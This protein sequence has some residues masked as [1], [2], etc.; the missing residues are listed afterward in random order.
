[1]HHAPDTSKENRHMRRLI[2]GI[3]CVAAAGAA[4]TGC[5]SAK[6]DAA[7]PGATEVVVTLTNDGCAPTPASVPAGP[8]TFKVTNTNGDAV[9]EAELKSGDTIVGEK[10]N[11]TPGLSGTFALKLKA[12]KY[13]VECPDAKTASYE[14]TVTGEAGTSALDPAVAAK[15]DTAVG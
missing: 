1:M 10:E 7:T 3:A 6:K 4:L 11:L 15:L 12:G 13:T 2:G 5:G 14:F 8:V 9:T